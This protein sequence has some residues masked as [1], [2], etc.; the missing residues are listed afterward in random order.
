[1]R[2]RP[3]TSSLC[4][5]RELSSVASG[6]ISAG[7]LPSSRCALAVADARQR[8]LQPA[9]RQQADPHLQQ[10]RHHQPQ[11][12]QQEGPDQGAVEGGAFRIHRRQI[13]RHHEGIGARVVRV[14]RGADG[15][16]HPPRQH[17]QMLVF[18]ARRHSHQLSA[19]RFCIAGDVRAPGRTASAKSARPAARP[20]R[21]DLVIEPGI[22]AVE[23]VIDETVL[24]HHAAI[25]IG[26][27]GGDQAVHVGR[28][29][30]RR[31]CPAAALRKALDST[32][33]PTT[34]PSMVQIAAAAIRRR[35]ERIKP[36]DAWSPRAGSSRL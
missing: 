19:P 14:R 32:T 27:G 12:Q 8:F 6:A 7:K 25:G 3:T 11:A 36:E 34:S 21:L 15:K 26:L 35:G 1:M 30:R 17:P 9:Q 28:Q 2:A 22:D 20:S 23:L 5:I 33:P 18:R 10:D 31:N 13:A 4:S 24:Q 16:F 29:A